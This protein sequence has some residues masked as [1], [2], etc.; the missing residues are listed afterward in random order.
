MRSCDALNERSESE[1]ALQEK[2]IAWN[3]PRLRV[4]PA[5]T[6]EADQG[7]IHFDGQGFVS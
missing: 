6:A 1:Q 4:L 2:R 7:G 3:A 5:E